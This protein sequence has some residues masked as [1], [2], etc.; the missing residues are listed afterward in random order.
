MRRKGKGDALS[1]SMIKLKDFGVSPIQLII[2]LTFTTVGFTVYYFVPLAL[3]TK[4]TYVFFFVMLSLLMGMILGMLLIGSSL[5]PQLERGIL[6]ILMMLRGRSDLHLATI[7]KKNLESHAPRNHK[8]TLMFM[9]TITFLIF[10][11]SGNT[12]FEYLVL[13]LTSAILNA[14]I[15][16]FIANVVKGTMPISIN[17][18]SIRDYLDVEAMRE[19]SI[20]KG[21][22][23]IGWTLNELFTQ[24][25]DEG[26]Y[27]EM[28]VGFGMK[29]LE[30]YGVSLYG[31]DHRFLDTGLI[32]YYYPEETLTQATDMQG[33][34][35]AMAGDLD[36]LKLMRELSIEN[37]SSYEYYQD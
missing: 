6:W 15:A 25:S 19:D 7:V 2:G 33:T 14:D 11:T 18:K 3:I 28:W 36:V 12:Q 30:L 16:L 34:T 10:C 35:H 21:Y 22:N 26:A 1:L 24:T 23:F 4:Q 5:I 9:I 20:V 27:N 29:N 17:E 31:F 32:E 37:R 13:S 8:T